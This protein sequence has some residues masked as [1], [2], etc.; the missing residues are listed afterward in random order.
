MSEEEFRQLQNE[1]ESQGH[2]WRAGPTTLSTLS[3]EEQALRLGLR[4]VPEEMERLVRL[5]AALGDIV[6]SFPPAWDWRQ[7]EG[8]NWTTPIRDQQA[9]GSCVA[10][11]TVAVLEA[12]LKLHDDAPDSLPDLSEAHLF[13]CGCGACCQEG[14]WPAYA[15]DYAQDQG[16]P[17]EVCFPYVDEDTP[18]DETCADWLS[19]AIKVSAWQEIVDAGQRKEWL[20]T[21]GPMIGC[22]EVYQDFFSYTGGVYHHATGA[23]AGYHAIC[24][25][26]YSEAEMAWICKNSW[27]AGWGEGGWFRIGYGECGI[28]QMFPMYGV[29]DVVAPGPTPPPPPPP[30]PPEPG[31]LPLSRI[32]RAL[33]GGQ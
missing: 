11:G 21:R 15:L 16:V 13:F 22:M 9:C 2:T 19:R 10:F 31:C 33:R 4:L 24:V 14:W 1:I 30:P 23:L 17:D 26:G 28:D 32:V 20:A 3:P 6:A 18:C 8:K 7:V 5:R 25:V 12:M 29:E 27:G